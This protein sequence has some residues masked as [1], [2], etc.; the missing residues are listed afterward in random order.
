M[1]YIMEGLYSLFSGNTLW[2]VYFAWKRVTASC[3]VGMFRLIETRYLSLLYTTQT[4]SECHNN[5]DTIADSSIA[6]LKEIIG[7][8][9]TKA[10]D[11]TWL[12]LLLCV[13]FLLTLFPFWM[14]GRHMPPQTL[15]FQHVDNCEHWNLSV[16]Y[17]KK[18]NKRKFILQ[19]NKSGADPAQN[20]NVAQRCCHLKWRHMTSRHITI[21]DVIYLFIDKSETEQQK[22]QARFSILCQ[23]S[24][25]EDP[26]ANLSISQNV[27]KR[28]EET[29]VA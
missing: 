5:F 10:A 29:F 15:F 2:Y 22:Y 4:S 28:V 8:M 6:R 11:D 25:C 20:L 18:R 7:P 24:W 16:F 12:N 1:I 9:A 21:H 27:F 26:F 17:R 3:K 14:V 13:T 23:F 19:T